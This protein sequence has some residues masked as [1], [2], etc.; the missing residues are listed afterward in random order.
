MLTYF[1]IFFVIVLALAPL[2]H[3]LPSKQQRRI[4]RLRE[5]AAVHGMFVEFRDLP[6]K[7]L[8]PRPDGEVIYY[9]K[10]LPASRPGPLTTAAW[11]RTPDSWR[12]VGER[13]PVPEAVQGLPPEILAASVDL[14]SCGVYWT[15]AGEVE[16]V[17]KIRQSLEQ[18][19]TALMT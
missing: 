19:C 5:Y 1:L 4:A 2:T 11:V 9:G 14:S 17:E 6:G 13:T 8:I 3:F 18:W 16:A 7:T 10:R 12:S 15:E